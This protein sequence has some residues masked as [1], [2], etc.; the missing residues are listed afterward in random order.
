MNFTKR[1]GSA[2]IVAVTMVGCVSATVTEPSACDSQ[3]VS[4]PV[5]SFTVPSTDCS[6][7]PSVSIPSEST[8]TTMD[9]SDDISKLQNVASNLNVSVTA[10]N[11]DNSNH[12]F[13]WVGEVDITV[14]GNGLPSALLA[15]YMQPSS[16][17]PATL[18]PQIAMSPADT[19]KYLSS[20]GLNVTLTLMGQTVTACQAVAAANDV[21]GASSV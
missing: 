7:L 6:T 8:T 14:Q 17:A 9:L 21:S 4:F 12:Q 19:L 2:L 1:L 5:P 13:D 20:G 11:I 10:F 15:K 16:G 18:E 3:S